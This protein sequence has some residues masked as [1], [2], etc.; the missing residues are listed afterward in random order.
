M[1]KIYTENFEKKLIEKIASAFR[2][3]ASEFAREGTLIIARDKLKN[4]N[5]MNIYQYQNKSFMLV[6]PNH[7]KPLKQTIIQNFRQKAISQNDVLSFWGT[8][9]E[10][11][12]ADEHFSYLDPEFFQ[13]IEET[14]EYS[15]RILN[16]DDNESYETLKESCSEYE[17]EEAYVY[18]ETGIV[19]GIWQKEELLGVANCID[20]DGIVE[21]IGIIVHPNFRRKGVGKRLLT[22]LCKWGIAENKLLQF[23]YQNEYESVARFVSSMGFKS[24]MTRLSCQF[25]FSDS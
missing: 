8:Q 14:E 15:I 11:L 2:C 17:W 22:E 13:P 20:W 1:E 6:D 23:R 4:S 5:R 18:L 10:I 9:V 12:S 16:A 24:F 25:D 7:F 3:D 19:F 21:D